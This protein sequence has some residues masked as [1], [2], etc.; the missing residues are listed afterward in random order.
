M[1]TH[2]CR[3]TG[4]Q[5]ELLYICSRCNRCYACHHTAVW[6]DDRW[7]WK[8]HLPGGKIKFEPVI[9]DGKLQVSSGL[10]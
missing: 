7:V 8:A 10:P 9:F 4:K 2:L 3:L 1:G 5:G 6:M